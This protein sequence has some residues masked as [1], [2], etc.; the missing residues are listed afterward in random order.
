MKIRANLKLVKQLDYVSELERDE[1]Y[2]IGCVF[3]AT[4]DEKGSICER[5]NRFSLTC[6]SDMIWVIDEEQWNSFKFKNDSF[7]ENK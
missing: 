3:H 5:V 1:C 2:C 4:S 7:K 6:G